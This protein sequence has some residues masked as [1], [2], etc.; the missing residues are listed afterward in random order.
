M[1]LEDV[2]A[3]AVVRPAHIGVLE[4]K[5]DI[6]RGWSGPGTFAPTGT[7]DADLDGNT[8]E[9]AAGA[10]EISGF[11]QDQGLGTPV[12]VSFAAGEMEDEDVVRQLIADRRAYLGRKARFWLGFLTADESSVLP[13]IEPMFSGVMVSAQTQRQPGDPAIIS[14][15]CDQDTQKANAAPLRWID[16]QTHYSGDTAT[17][18]INDLSRGAIAGAAVG[19][20]TPFATPDLERLYELRHDPIVGPMLPAN[21]NEAIDLL[22][23]MG[24][25]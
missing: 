3:A 2:L 20:V 12:T 13:E 16:H 22:R 21:D 1:A 14:V 8:F 7:G 17:S 24:V 10:V 5:D 23:G 4:F 15:T 25:L 11:G 18:H 19:G 6:L 9:S